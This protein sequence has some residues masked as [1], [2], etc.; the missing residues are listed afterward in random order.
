MNCPNGFFVNHLGANRPKKELQR[1]G[2]DDS[3]W[4]HDDGNEANY[5]RAGVKQKERQPDR[6]PDNIQYCLAYLLDGRYIFA[7]FDK[8]VP[9]DAFAKR[10][11]HQ[12]GIFKQRVCDR[13]ANNR[14]KK[15]AAGD[16]IKAANPPPAQ[17][18]P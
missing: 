1:S 13:Y 15:D 10:E 7:A 6:K 8:R 11:K 18:K 17:Y 3:D 5:D 16:Q 2:N 14:N 9:Y 4:D 12:L